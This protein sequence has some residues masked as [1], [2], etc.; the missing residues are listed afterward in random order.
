MQSSTKVN[1]ISGPTACPMKLNPLRFILLNPLDIATVSL[2]AALMLT[3]GHVRAES[4]PSTL[5]ADSAVENTERNAR[6]SGKATLTPEDQKE[7][8]ADI[9]ITTAIRKA[10]VKKQS[11]SL[12]AHNAKIITRNGVVTL[13]GPV[14]NPTE[15]L[16]L[17]TIAEKSKGVKHVD[18][19]LETK[20]P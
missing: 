14:E 5:V 16:Q 11:L 7:T 19:Q 17:Q 3:V 2:M 4:A 1:E 6:D 15:K 10:I 12:D 13:R 20:T 18:N 9:K 8:S